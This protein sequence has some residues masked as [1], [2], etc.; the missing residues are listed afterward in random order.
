MWELS[1]EGGIL[2]HAAMLG[3]AA[4]L[5]L[6]LGER[7]FPGRLHPVVW[8]GKAIGWSTEAMFALSRR[9]HP[10]PPEGPAASLG[11]PG[12]NEED[13]GC[14][15]KS[16]RITEFVSGLVMAI[17]IPGSFAAGAYFALDGIRGLSN[18]GYILVGALMLKSTFAV[19]MLDR[20]ASQVH[21]SLAAGRLEDAR[22]DLRGLV[23]RD[24]SGLTPEL[25]TAAVVESVSENTTDSFLAPWLA[26]ALFGVPGAVAYRAI[27]TL[28][29]MIGYHGYYEY[30]GKASA[31]LDDAVNLVPARLSAFLIMLGGIPRPLWQPTGTPAERPVDSLGRWSEARNAWRIAMRDHA[32]TESPNAGWP[33]SA[34]AG[35]LGVR[36]E[37][38][39]HY[40]LGDGLRPLAPQDIKRA[41]GRMYFVAFSGL[42]VTLV[43]I[44]VK[45]AII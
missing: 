24:T 42:A 5:D 25:A 31:R 37:K 29:S 1:L 33:M 30:L 32:Q 41:V 44:L 18:I 22:A 10:P 36:L 15:P 38:V 3:L 7:I 11:E 8:M 6:T 16:R 43:V 26:F 12:K 17:L 28:D 2:P 9:L 27:N 19:R 20:A 39:G 14:Y 23:S 34:M 21:G 13:D 35:S 4:L 45:Y 40:K